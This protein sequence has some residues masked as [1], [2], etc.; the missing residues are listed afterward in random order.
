MVI[1]YITLKSCSHNFKFADSNFVK[2]ST[3]GIYNFNEKRSFTFLPIF[4]TLRKK[5]VIC[6]SSL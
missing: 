5:P 1:S 6:L 2:N 3:S 4:V